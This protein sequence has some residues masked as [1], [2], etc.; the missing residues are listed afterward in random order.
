MT[1]GLVEAAASGRDRDA[2]E[3]CKQRFKKRPL[4]RA[5]ERQQHLQILH[6]VAIDREADA[7]QRAVD[8]RCA[9]LVGNDIGQGFADRLVEHVMV[10]LEILDDV[11]A[12][13]C[14]NPAI[15]APGQT[16]VEI[17]ALEQDFLQ[18]AVALRILNQGFERANPDLCPAVFK[19]GAHHRLFA[20]ANKRIADRLGDLLAPRDRKA[21]LHG[22]RADDAQQLVVVEQIRMQQHRPCNLDA[23]VGQLHNERARRRVFLGQTLGKAATN[24]HFQL[25]Q[26]ALQN[27]FG[28]FALACRHGAQIGAQ[29]H[30]AHAC[31]QMRAGIRALVLGKK[32]QALQLCAVELRSHF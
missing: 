29:N 15:H 17:F 8:G 31:R 2:R 10:D 3:L 20:G 25:M 32:Q 14:R 30:V 21:M 4:A 9:P 23:I 28:K 24:W 16:R 7:L 22:A 18:V 12:Q 5:D 6:F 1:A 13:C 27:L 11:V 19:H 26:E